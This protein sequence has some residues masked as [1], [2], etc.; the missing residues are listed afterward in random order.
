VLKSRGE[1]SLSAFVLSLQR[2]CAGKG[3]LLNEE[4]KIKNEK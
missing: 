3:F 4:L 1:K 2:V